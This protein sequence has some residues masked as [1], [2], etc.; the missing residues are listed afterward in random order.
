MVQRKER[1]SLQKTVIDDMNSNI[2][3]DILEGL[4]S[5]ASKGTP[6]SMPQRKV[7]Y[8]MTDDWVYSIACHNIEMNIYRLVRSSFW[9][10][11]DNV[12]VFRKDGVKQMN[13]EHYVVM[14][15]SSAIP[16]ELKYCEPYNN[17]L[18]I[19]NE[20]HHTK[21]RC[22]FKMNETAY[23]D[24]LIK[25]LTDH[26]H[27]VVLADEPPVKI[28]PPVVEPPPV[29]EQPTPV[30]E[31]PVVVE[32]PPVVEQPVVK[33]KSSKKVKTVAPSPVVPVV[34]K[35]SKSRKSAK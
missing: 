6:F 27:S 7:F 25:N 34:K 18:A 13:T 22:P 33:S 11:A 29:V 1:Q 4:K 14:P 23:L 3:E 9:V 35:T 15:T 19:R 32:P 17:H 8:F 26:E 12:A 28:K 21:K 5:P 2:T 10:N 31:Q 20:I 30:V 24:M 16:S